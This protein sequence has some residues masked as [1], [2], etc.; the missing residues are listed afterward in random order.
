MVLVNRGVEYLKLGIDVDHCRAV[1]K[2]KSKEKDVKEG[3]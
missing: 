1:V 2:I 3:T